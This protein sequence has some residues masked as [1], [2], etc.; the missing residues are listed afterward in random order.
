MQHDVI[1]VG[2][3]SAG[4]VLAR[5]L[6]ESCARSVLLLEAGPDYA[7]PRKL[8]A[9]LVDGTRNSM[10]QHDWGYAHKPTTRS[11][12]YPLPRGRVVGGS[13][14]VNTCI[15][16]RGQPEDYDE[17][18]ARGLPAW[19]WEHCFP[20]FKRLERDLDVQNAWHGQDGPLPIRRHPSEEWVPWQA[21]FVEAC[22]ELGFPSCYDSNEPGSWGVGPHAM[23]KLAGRRISVAEAYL[24]PE[25]RARPNFTLRANT[26]IRRILLRGRQVIGV[27][28]E[29]EQGD[30][31]TLES[32]HVVLAAGALNTPHILLR[33][34]IGPRDQIER[35]GCQVLVEVP[36]INRRLLD[37]PG[38][39]FFLMPRDPSIA[40]FDHPLIQTV[41][42]YTSKHSNHRS[43]I[44]LQ[45]G[46][47]FTMP[48]IDL[49]PLSLMCSV[50]K[51]QDRG[52]SLRWLSSDPRAKPVVELRMLENEHDRA[53]AVEAMEIGYEL[54]QSK[55]LSALAVQMWPGERVLRSRQKIDQWIRFA[56]GSGY[57]P[58]G[59]VPMGS[60]DDPDAAT[61]GEGRLR[62]VVGLTIADA[63]LMPTIPSSNI[64]LPTLMVAERIAEFLTR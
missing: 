59:T 17:W 27:E 47:R 50:G 23:N 22:L 4:S 18:A 9:D 57:H 42:R 63:S 32:A 24:T 45:P 3:G 19:S 20:A 26:M 8:P 21:G 58:C 31:E 15:A 2:A 62:G 53:V 60:D 46:S 10:I 51:P 54:M 34:G 35:I 29:N 25:V 13:S 40:S 44:L 5:R 64:H 55:S 56:C 16:L 6:S 48:E 7:D 14:A 38:T 11:G 33:S 43:D 1:V 28:V 37:H 36:Q 52:G 12:Y 30:V 41:F 61:D 39:A 49:V